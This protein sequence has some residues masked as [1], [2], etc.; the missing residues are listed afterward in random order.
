MKEAIASLLWVFSIIILTMCLLGVIEIKRNV[1]EL[2]RELNEVKTEHHVIIEYKE[3]PKDTIRIIMPEKIAAA[4][5]GLK[6]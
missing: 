1:R 5:Y 6:W 3:V 2:K 4:R